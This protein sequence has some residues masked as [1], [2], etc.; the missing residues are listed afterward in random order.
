VSPAAESRGVREGRRPTGG[1]IVQATIG[2]GLLVAGA[3]WLADYLRER[4]DEGPDPRLAS[5]RAAPVAPVPGRDDPWVDFHLDRRTD[6]G[7]LA[8]IDFAGRR[9]WLAVGRSTEP[10]ATVFARILEREGGAARAETTPPL[11]SARAV[12][13]S[14]AVAGRVGPGAFLAR[15]PLDPESPAGR[16]R[17]ERGSLTLAIEAS[18]GWDHLAF[19]FPEGID[20]AVGPPEVAAAAQSLARLGPAAAAHLEPLFQETL[21]ARATTSSPLLVVCRPRAPLRETL[22]VLAEDLATE[23]WR[24][25]GADPDAGLVLERGA[26]Q[27]WVVPSEP[28]AGAVLVLLSGS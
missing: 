26:E 21:G 3:L 28:S 20:L 24:T 15:L 1:R 5:E 8:P 19:L 9:A 7:P 25:V 22:L 18:G 10:P 6:Y 14:T 23:G 27:A 11:G 12:F 13:R 16:L 17:A 4:G 2:A